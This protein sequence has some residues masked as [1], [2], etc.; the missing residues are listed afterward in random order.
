MTD[1]NYTNAEKV[2][3]LVILVGRLIQ[4]VRKHDPDNDV[5]EKALDYLKRANLEP[6]IL[7]GIKDRQG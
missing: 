4:Q 1:N 2:G 3:N 7:R 6:S 5:V